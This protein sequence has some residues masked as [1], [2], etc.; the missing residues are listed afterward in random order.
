MRKK[1][2]KNDIFPSADSFFFHLEEGGEGEA[3]KEKEKVGIHRFVKSFFF[4]SF[5]SQ[6]RKNVTSHL[7]RMTYKCVRFFFFSA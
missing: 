1:N 2:K 6:G 3:S 7:L 5:F 4:L